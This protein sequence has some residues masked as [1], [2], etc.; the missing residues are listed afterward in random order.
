[1]L[2]IFD[3]PSLESVK[4][5]YTKLNFDAV[6]AY[7]MLTIYNNILDKNEKRRI[8]KI[9]WFDEFEEWNIM[10]SHY[11]VSFAK[12][13]TKPEKKPE[14]KSEED[15]YLDLFNNYSFMKTQFK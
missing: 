5:R 4:A 13:L 6:E 2:G 10:Q 15:A 7:D 9:E 12:K 3:Y 1:M 14:E 11:F 8:E